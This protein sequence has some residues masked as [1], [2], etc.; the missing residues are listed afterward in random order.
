MVAPICNPSTGELGFQGH[1]VSLSSE[2]ERSLGKQ[3][4]GEMSYQVK[5]C[6]APPQNPGFGAWNLLLQIVL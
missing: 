1:V 3:W 2:F 5:A 6:A 4:A